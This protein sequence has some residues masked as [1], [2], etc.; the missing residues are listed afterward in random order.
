MDVDVAGKSPPEREQYIGVDGGAP[1]ERL[2]DVDMYWTQQSVCIC[3]ESCGYALDR[4]RGAPLERG[5]DLNREAPLQRDVGVELDGV[6][7]L[8]RGV[9]MDREAMRE[10][11]VDVDMNRE[12]P[13]QREVGV[14]L[15]GVAP[16]ER[17]GQRSTTGESCR[18]GYERRSTIGEERTL[19][20]YYQREVWT[21]ID[22]YCKRKV[23]MWTGKCH[24][25]EE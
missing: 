22:E 9:D 13:L 3:G 14:E 8:E 16:L 4:D 24:Q 11:V 2:M 15:D 20:W 7:P 25:K 12:A 23:W 17:G 1:P 21:W 6:A 19:M 18:C 10:R 5:V